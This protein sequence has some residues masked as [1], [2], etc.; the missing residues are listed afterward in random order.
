MRGKQGFR[1]PNLFKIG[2]YKTPGR[3]NTYNWETEWH[4]EQGELITLITTTFPRIMLR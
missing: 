4:S 2:M 3:N 1:K